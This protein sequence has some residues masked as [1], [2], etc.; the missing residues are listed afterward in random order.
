VPYFAGKLVAR[1]FDGDKEV[2]SETIKTTGKAF[3]IRLKADRATIKANKNDLA[4]IDVEI[5]DE[6]GNVVPSE[7]DV[8]VKYQIAGNGRILGVGN[9]NP[10]DMSSFQKP[11]KRV[12]QGK[13]L[14][15]VQPTERVG[16]ITIK[17][18]VRGL[19]SGIVKIKTY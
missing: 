3:A 10:R 19:K 4:Y 2:A 9:G 17:A 18:E 8:L 13:G 6:Q 1:C 16:E 15:I 11:E 12:F 14:V 5:V 7:D